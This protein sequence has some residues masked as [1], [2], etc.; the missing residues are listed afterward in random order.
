MRKYEVGSFTNGDSDICVQYLPPK[1]W[2]SSI[3]LKDKAEE[4]L[5]QAYF[6][7]E[8]SYH[9]PLVEM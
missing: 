1:T 4:Q 7:L 8:N 3:I 6:A 2:D 5:H 9:K